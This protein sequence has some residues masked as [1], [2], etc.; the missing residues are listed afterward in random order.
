MTYDVGNPKMFYFVYRIYAIISRP[1][2]KFEGLS[3]LELKWFITD[4]LIYQF[5]I[6]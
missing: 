3:S 5:K 2:Y 6:A 1:A 4:M